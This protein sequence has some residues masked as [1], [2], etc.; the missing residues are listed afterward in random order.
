M[1]I[2]IAKISLEIFKVNLKMTN[3]KIQPI[4]IDNHI[5]YLCNEIDLIINDIKIET[6]NTTKTIIE[7]SFVI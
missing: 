3:A 7:I 5:P 6:T 2:S 4:A 1:S